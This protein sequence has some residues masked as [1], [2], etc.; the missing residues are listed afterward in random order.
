M[1]LFW[2]FPVVVH[3]DSNNETV[4]VLLMPRNPPEDHWALASGLPT[5]VAESALVSVF[6][7]FCDV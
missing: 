7:S 3:E 1:L 2:L 5:Y 6:L 4:F